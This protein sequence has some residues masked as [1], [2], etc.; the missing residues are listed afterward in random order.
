MAGSFLQTIY[1]ISSRLCEAM[2]TEVTRFGKCVVLKG[3]KY[4]KPLALDLAQVRP[5]P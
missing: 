3:I 4:P 5:G 1:T 2:I